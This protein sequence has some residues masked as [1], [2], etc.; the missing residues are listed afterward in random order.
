[1]WKAVTI[2]CVELFVRLCAMGYWTLITVEISS[3]TWDLM[4]IQQNKLL[5]NIS[6][7]AVLVSTVI[8]LSFKCTAL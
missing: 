2:T 3:A 1:M 5:S 7:V 4:L 6:G 8:H